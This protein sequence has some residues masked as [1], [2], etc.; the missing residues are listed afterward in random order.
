MFAAVKR[1]AMA[2]RAGPAPDKVGHRHEQS[3]TRPVSVAK[4]SPVQGNL[5]AEKVKIVVLVLDRPSWLR[6]QP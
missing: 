6:L 3:P 2:C 1:L 4:G 5:M